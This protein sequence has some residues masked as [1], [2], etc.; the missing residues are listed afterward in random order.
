LTA[1]ADGVV[2]VVSSNMPLPQQAYLR[3]VAA[4]AVSCET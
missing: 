3:L 4:D 1:D 2:A